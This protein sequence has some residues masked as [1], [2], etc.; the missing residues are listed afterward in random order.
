MDLVFRAAAVFIFIFA[1]TRL[2][3]RRE[4]YSLEP[5]DLILLVVTGDLVQ[6]ADHAERLFGHGWVHRDLRDR[7]VDRCG[8]LSELPRP[9]AQAGCSKASRSSCVENGRPIE[10]NLRRERIT[11]EDAG[12]GGAPAAG[13]S[14]QRRAACGARDQRRHQHHPH[15]LTQGDYPACDSGYVPGR[16]EHQGGEH[17]P[18]DPHPR[19]ARPAAV[20]ALPLDDRHRARHRLDPRRARGHDRRQH[21]R[22][23]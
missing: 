13:R 22:R 1:I 8:Q 2:V 19:P 4:L 11:V 5:F 20:V 10:R 18:R 6:Q 7:L 23:G 16:R 9:A 21:R 15:G 17:D 12:G 14:A 3:G